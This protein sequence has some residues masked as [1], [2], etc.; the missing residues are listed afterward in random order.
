MYQW[1]LSQ[2]NQYTTAQPSIQI[3]FSLLLTSDKNRYNFWSRVLWLTNKKARGKKMCSSNQKMFKKNPGT[4]PGSQS[5]FC[6]LG[7]NPTCPYLHECGLTAGLV[8]ALFASGRSWPFETVPSSLCSRS[9]PRFSHTTRWQ[10]PIHKQGSRYLFAPAQQLC[11]AQL[12]HTS[13]P[14]CCLR[15]RLLVELSTRVALHQHPT[16]TIYSFALLNDNKRNF[17]KHPEGS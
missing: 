5:S 16:R 9:L 12:R 11:Q 6:T 8:L 1:N 3:L 10:V 7:S 4:L 13:A 14:A 15:H 17:H 2:L